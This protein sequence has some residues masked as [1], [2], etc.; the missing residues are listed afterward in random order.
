MTYMDHARCG[1]CAKCT[2]EL[3]EISHEWMRRSPVAPVLDAPEVTRVKLLRHA[4]R[5]GWDQV[6][7][8]AAEH[9]IYLT[10][11]PKERA[12]SKRAKGPTLKERIAEM[13][14]RKPDTKVETI[15]EVENLSPS[16]AR[17]LVAEVKE[18]LDIDA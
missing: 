2:R 15:A 14:E 8:T 17:R 5:H 13:L 1:N 12:T 11:P 7:E 9:G 3:R 16:R 10:P 4:A 6:V 18:T